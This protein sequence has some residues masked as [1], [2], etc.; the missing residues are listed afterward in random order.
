MLSGAASPLPQGTP[1]VFFM[2]LFSFT[3]KGQPK[4]GQT[5]NNA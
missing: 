2:A 3:Q 4:L 1:S 5:T